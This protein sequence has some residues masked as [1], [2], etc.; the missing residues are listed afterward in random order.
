VD[1]AKEAASSQ[2]WKEKLHNQS[3][4]NTLMT[5]EIFIKK[6]GITMP[7]WD[8]GLPV[9][10]QELIREASEILPMTGDLV[11]GVE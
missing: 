6:F 3:K 7:N 9:E 4:S 10:Q 1:N 2:A 11:R 5:R 8:Y